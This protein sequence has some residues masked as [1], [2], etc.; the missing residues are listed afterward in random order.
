MMRTPSGSSRENGDRYLS[1]LLEFFPSAFRAR[2]AL[3]MH[4]LLEEMKAELGPRP[5]AWQLG[6]LYVAVTW[7]VLR[8]VRAEHRRVRRRRSSTG[9]GLVDAVA[10]SD[11]GLPVRPRSRKRGAFG[12]D[13]LG[14][15]RALRHAPGM[16][17]VVVVTLAVGIGSVTTT[18]SV[19]NGVLLT[20]IQLTQPENL[21]TIWGRSTTSPQ[22]PLSVSDLHTLRAEA[23]V[24]EAVVARW[25][26][27]ETVD[28]GNSPQQVH[29]AYVTADYLPV[30]G[31]SPSLGRGFREGEEDVVVLSHAFW[32]TRFQSDPDVL[33][34]QLRVKT[35]LMTVVGVLPE[36]RNPEMPTVG[37]LR[38][39]NAIWRVMPDGYISGEDWE[40]GWMRG[41]GRLRPGVS[42]AQ[43]DEDLRR[44]AALVRTLDDDRAATDF[45]YYTTPVLEELV[46]RVRP[47]L[48]TLM[49]AV[50]LVLVTACINVANLLLARADSRQ[51]EL[52]VRRAL[53]ADGSDV[54]RRVGLE[55]GLLAA[56]GGLA[57]LI[58][59]WAGG[60]LIASLGPA[61]LPRLEL[62]TVN[63]DVLA[64]TAGIAMLSAFVFGTIPA[65]RSL[66]V[67]PALAL[68]SRGSSMTR[69]GARV[70]QGFV[71]A[72]VGSSIVLVTLVAVMVQTVHRLS[73]IRPGY[74]TGST[75][76]MSFA[77]TRPFEGRD[78][79]VAHQQAIVE[80]V[81]SLPT[82]S[83]AGLTNRTPLAGGLFTGRYST[84]DPGEDDEGLP[85]A[86]IRYV[87]RDYFSAMGTAI[88]S[89]R[90][91]TASDDDAVAI[92]DRR[93][94][95]TSWPN[96][97]PVGQS[98]WVEGDLLTIV[99]VVEHM[100]HAEL[101]SDG[102]PTVFQPWSAGGGGGRVFLA[103]R[104]N[105]P[106]GVPDEAVR[107]ALQAIDPAGAVA[108]VRRMRGRVADA[109]ATERL[110]MNMS[111]LF[112]VVAL[113]L[114]CLGLYAVIAFSV[115]RRTRE[116]GIRRAL[117]ASQ[118]KV[119]GRMMNNG[120][121][122]VLVGEAI[123]LIG[124]VAATRALAGFLFGIEPFDVLS[125]GLALG[126]VT[127]AGIVSVL[128]PS[129]RA[130]KVSPVEALRDS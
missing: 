26:A 93:M 40:T 80:A 5:R 11:W 130:T 7:D 4:E 90:A 47:I 124:A 92:V 46:A 104:G 101:Y 103:V 34:R 128:L 91:F 16:A 70:T 109:M 18:F 31:V 86:S 68:A 49:A 96:V 94:V 19:V 63:I 119:I 54:L 37:G 44:V 89:G 72:Q 85:S 125:L 120:L 14:A 78:D 23:S 32:K 2:Y 6:R 100:R 58:V 69:G 77:T 127:I 29:V 111:I 12:R 87:T 55:A 73:S 88:L 75:L 79:R 71:A 74:D 48:L 123:G 42:R 113:F 9:Q 25:T 10:T 15:T 61:V 35:S 1:L 43:A 60:R 27:R 17:T 39:D 53:G 21:V 126:V 99:G 95:S 82:V 107:A 116:I 118:A 112:G 45:G 33:G 81:A 76:T 22:K 115:V 102:R 24:F 41:I 13:L 105:T 56:L 3:A 38:E 62:V 59:A 65:F 117:G 30:L 57:G 122:L 20:P 84:T 114:A 51:T 97:N 98:L 36:D 129:L 83:A 110:A 108:D 28:D 8:R 67:D 106:S 52:A 66:R 50:V 121:R 64:F